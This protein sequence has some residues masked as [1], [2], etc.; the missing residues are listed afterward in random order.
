MGNDASSIY[1]KLWQMIDTIDD[2]SHILP[3]SGGK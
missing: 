1:G 2:Q 3:L